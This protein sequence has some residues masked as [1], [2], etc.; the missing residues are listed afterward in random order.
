V[1]DKTG[2]STVAHELAHF[3]SGNL[4]TNATWNDFWLNEGFTS[5]LEYRIME[6]AFG[7]RKAKINLAQRV[8]EVKSNDLDPTYSR[9]LMALKLNLVKDPEDGMSYIP[10]GKGFFFLLEI[11]KTVGRESMDSF[12]KSYFTQFKFKSLTTGDFTQYLSG[13]FMN[14]Y[15]TLLEDVQ[16]DKWIHG[17][18]IPQYPAVDPDLFTAID[19]GLL[20]WL[21]GENEGFLIN[22]QDWITEDWVYLLNKLITIPLTKVQLKSIDVSITSSSMKDSAAILSA[23]Y[24]LAVNNNY[25]EDNNDLQTFLIKIGRGRY[26]K[27]VYK[28][29]AKTPSGIEFGKV[30]FEKAKSGYHPSLVNAVTAILNPTN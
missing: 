18:D 12:L 2:I 15:P 5:Y 21:N 26:V 30:C 22:N 24:I 7:E 23:W 1:G 13:Y 16:A 29:L 11:E 20:G 28:Q 14:T 8:A 25:S 27:P 6:K 17:K 19:D 10:Y 3:W 4:V 9:E